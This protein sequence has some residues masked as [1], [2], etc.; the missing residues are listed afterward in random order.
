MSKYRPLE[1][2]LA[3]QGA[4]KK[5]CN[6]R[7][8]EIEGI[9]KFPLPPSARTHRG[10]WTNDPNGTHVQARAWMGAGWRVWRT[11]LNSERVE[12]E[13]IVSKQGDGVQ[14]APS[15]YRHHASRSDAMDLVTFDRSKLNVAARR[16][17]DDYTAEFDGDVQ[18]ALDKALEEARIAYRKRF[19]DSIP[20][21]A[22]TTVD[23]VDLIR[24]GRDGR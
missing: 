19:M 21:G 6:L 13:R 4:E 2:F 16:I 24:D 12:F 14:E 3:K 11:D 10:W 23:S 5:W 8:G 7:F 9:L 22:P 15:T 17:L 20:R 18:R 1:E